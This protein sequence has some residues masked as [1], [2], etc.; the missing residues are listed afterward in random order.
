MIHQK[1]NIAILKASRKA[2]RLMVGGYWAVV[3]VLLALAM[4]WNSNSDHEFDRYSFF[5]FLLLGIPV[6]MLGESI[7]DQPTRRMYWPTRVTPPANWVSGQPFRP[8][9]EEWKE[10]PSSADEREVW[11]RSNTYLKA[12]ALVKGVVWIAVIALMA[13][14][15]RFLKELA[16]L[17][18]IVIWI[19]FLAVFSLPP[20]IRLWTEPDMEESSQ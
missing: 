6:R 7:V 20:S 16:F 1:G 11:V 15:L 14:D 8:I 2:R 18:E 3:L 9:F 19:L 12:Y 17:R 13:M 5:L 4:C 10:D